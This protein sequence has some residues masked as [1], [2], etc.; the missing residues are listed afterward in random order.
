M[1]ALTKFRS[2][3]ELSLSDVYLLMENLES[4]INSTRDLA[5]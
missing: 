5:A 4:K 2:T 1:L 3:S